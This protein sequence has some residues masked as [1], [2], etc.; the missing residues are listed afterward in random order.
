VIQRVPSTEGTSELM[1]IG[2]VVEHLKKSSGDRLLV[3]GCRGEMNLFYFR[4]GELISGYFADPELET[5]EDSVEERLLTYVYNRAGQGA[6]SL[7]VFSSMAAASAD[8]GVFERGRWPDELVEHF[9]RPAPHLLIVGSDGTTRR[10]ELAAR[11]VTLGRSQE[12]DL[13]VED[14]AISRRHLIFRQEPDG[15]SV[16]D[17]GSRNGTLYNGAPLTRAVLSHGSEL[18]TGECLIRFFGAVTPAES[19]AAADHGEET[20]CRPAVEVPASP[21]EPPEAPSS[22]RRTWV[23]DIVRNDGARDRLPMTGKITTVG[24]AKA[25]L[26]L[27]DSRVSRRHGEFEV[28]PDGVTYRDTGSTNGSL[29]NGRAVTSAVLKPGDVLKLGDSSVTILQEAA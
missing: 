21:S 6:L 23:L 4:A 3:V 22:P 15:V 1:D 11:T 19:M 14:P 28:G 16:E 25:D 17:C 20:I 5:G 8:D 2:G 7:Y 26:V 18:Q 27:T 10:Y 13:V 9:A 24:R 12:N 29:L